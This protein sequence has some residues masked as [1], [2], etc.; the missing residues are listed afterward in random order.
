MSEQHTNPTRGIVVTGKDDPVPDETP[1]S[2]ES[3]GP[4]LKQGQIPSSSATP[5]FGESSRPVSHP[6]QFQ[7]TTNDTYDYYPEDPSWEDEESDIEEPVSLFEV[8]RRGA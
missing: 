8:R 5:K 4:P 6:N 1:T 3:I 7:E 2:P